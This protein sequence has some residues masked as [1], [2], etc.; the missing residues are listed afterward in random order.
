MQWLIILS[1]I[2]FQRRDSL[3]HYACQLPEEDKFKLVHFTL[4]GGGVHGTWLENNLFSDGQVEMS[5]PTA[6]R[7]MDHSMGAEKTI[8]HPDY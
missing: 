1:R 3:S 6:A 5:S 8:Q 7:S 2:Y 4:P